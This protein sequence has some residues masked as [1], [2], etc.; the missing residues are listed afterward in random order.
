MK[1]VDLRVLSLRQKKLSLEEFNFSPL[2]FKLKNWTPCKSSKW[3]IKLFLWLD[4]VA[5]FLIVIRED[6]R[7]HLSFCWNWK[8]LKVSA[9]LTHLAVSILG[10]DLFQV[11]IWN[12]DATLPDAVSAS[13]VV[14]YSFQ[15]CL[16]EK[17]L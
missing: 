6:L 1:K 3:E 7:R 16:F 5:S 14:G 4:N 9:I 10:Q 15:M 2:N 11:G 12:N 13:S 8:S 17:I